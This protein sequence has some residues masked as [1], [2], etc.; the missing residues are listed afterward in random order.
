MASRK[1]RPSAIESGAAIGSGRKVGHHMRSRCFVAC[2]FVLAVLIVSALPGVALAAQVQLP[3]GRTDAA[4]PASMRS[5]ST[6][7]PDVAQQ[8]ETALSASY[9]EL[10]FPGAVIGVYTPQGDWVAAIGVQDMS[11]GQPWPSMSIT[12]SAV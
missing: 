10:G 7:P 2:R 12:G 4:A 6:V 3:P 9:G 5:T 1:G 8:L 11:T